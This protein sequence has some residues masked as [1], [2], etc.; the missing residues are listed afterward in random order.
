MRFKEF[1]QRFFSKNAKDKVAN[2]IKWFDDFGVLPLNDKVNA[3]IILST[4]GT[5]QQYEGYVVKI[6]HKDKGV[7]SSKYFDFNVYMTKR[8]DDR[9][10][11]K[12]SF[13]ILSY[14]CN[15]WYI[16]IPDKSEVD[17][18]TKEILDF[19]NLWR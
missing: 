5:S 15:D 13:K 12:L 9:Q 6:V 7:L 14:V 3:E 17:K 4:N 19:I 8:I 1:N 10:R 11:E 18:M 2:R 16:A